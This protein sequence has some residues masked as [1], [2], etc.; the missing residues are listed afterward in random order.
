MYSQP[1]VEPRSNYHSGDTAGNGFPFRRKTDANQCE[2]FTEILHRIL[3]FDDVVCDRMTDSIA[4]SRI[5]E[6]SMNQLTGWI[7]LLKSASWYAARF[8]VVEGVLW[9][10]VAAVVALRIDV[11]R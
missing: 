3:T 10:A 9:M 11:R 7:E 6:G 4:S 1:A 8:N 2:R 5:S